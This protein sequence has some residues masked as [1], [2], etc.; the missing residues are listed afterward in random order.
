MIVVIG[1]FGWVD[2]VW[3][4]AWTVRLQVFDYSQLSDYNCTEWLVKNK[5]ANAP[6]KF[7]ETVIV[8]I[9]GFIIQLLKV[10][11]KWRVIRVQISCD[12]V[13]LIILYRK[14]KTV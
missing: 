5:A 3:L 12:I 13:Q 6:I 14:K 9:N 10:E 8:M 4:T 7:E 1:G 11:Y 2:P